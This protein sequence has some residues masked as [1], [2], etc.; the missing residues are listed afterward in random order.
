MPTEEFQIRAW[1]SDDAHAQVLVHASPAGEIR[2]PLTVPCDVAALRGAAAFLDESEWFLDERRQERLVALG[3]ALAEVLLPRPVLALLTSSLDR[4]ASDS[5]L[6]VRLCLDEELIDLPW[7]YLYRPD[8]AESADAMDPR[9]RA[10]SPSALTGFLLFDHR[11]SL[12]REAPRT[13]Q[14]LPGVAKA[15]RM[16]VVGALW[17]VGGVEEDRWLVRDEYDALVAALGAVED[18]M[19]LEFLPATGDIEAALAEPTAVLHYTGHA[20]TDNGSGYLVRQVTVDAQGRTTIPSGDRLHSVELAPMLRRARTRLAVF[21]ACN[22]GRW[23]FV[24]P[25]LRSGVPAVLGAQGVLT[26]HAAHV[27]CETLYEKLTVGLSLD[28]ALIGARFRMLK[29]G[30][31]GGQDSVEWGQFMAYL[32]STEAVLFPRRARKAADL[33]TTARESSEAAI[34]DVAERLGEAPA[35]A[36]AVNQTTLRKAIV[37]AFTIAEQAVLVADVRQ[38]IA[39]DGVHLDLD[40]DTLGG[41]KTPEET[42]V[43]NLIQFLDRRGYLSYLVEKVRAER[44]GILP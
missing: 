18:L 31:Y 14:A 35:A 21:S 39:D 8:V 9:S 30:G 24:E 10:A 3:R 42:L 16:L 37:K 33:R 7:E 2:K 1:R 34:A 32:P 43:L 36:S 11:V 27:F 5:I 26:A 38:A 19:S 41:P 17:S 29:E 15:Q 4:L 13:V 12:V 23:S 40:L 20:E 28:E 6:R 25:L 22:S 44:P